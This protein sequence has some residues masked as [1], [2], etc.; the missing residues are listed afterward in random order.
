MPSSVVAA[1]K[2]SQETHKLRVT[3][4]SGHVY[5]YK[6]I[7]EIIFEK[8]KAAASKG[9]FLNRVIKDG[10]DFEKIK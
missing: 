10:F 6:N 9:V 5:D 8:M 3:Y 7:P 1:M 2:Y 4:V